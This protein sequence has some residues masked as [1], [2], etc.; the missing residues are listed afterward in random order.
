[1]IIWTWPGGYPGY[2]PPF[3]AGWGIPIQ[4]WSGV[5]QV[6]PTIQTWGT[7]HLDLGWGTPL[8]HRPRTDTVPPLPASVDRLKILPSPILRMRAVEIGYRIHSERFF[9]TAQSPMQSQLS[10]PQMT[11]TEF[12]EKRHLY[13]KSSMVGRDTPFHCCLWMVSI[14]RGE[15]QWIFWFL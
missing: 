5:P 14:H 7:P 3:R 13:S 2:P 15:S 12:S 11:F 8:T 10:F 4:T 6:P 9:N 1:M